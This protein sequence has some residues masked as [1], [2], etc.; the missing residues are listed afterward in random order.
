MRQ[1]E[2]KY[3][4]EY[5]AQEQACAVLERSKAWGIAPE[6]EDRALASVQKTA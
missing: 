3:K 2:R 6:Q 4:R 1:L 5:E